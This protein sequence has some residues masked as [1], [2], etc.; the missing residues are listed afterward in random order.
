[1]QMTILKLNLAVVINYI[2]ALTICVGQVILPLHPNRRVVKRLTREERNVLSRG[3]KPLEVFYNS[4]V[5]ASIDHSITPSK[6]KRLSKFKEARLSYLRSSVGNKDHPGHRRRTANVS[7]P[8]PLL[9]GYGSHYVTAYVGTPPQRT[10]LLVDT[11]SSVT[12]FP[13]VCCEDGCG[14]HTDSYFD[15][16]KSETYNKLS[17]EECS[18]GAICSDNQCLVG[19]SYLEGSHWNGYQVTDKFYL[20]C[21]NH[22]DNSKA[23]SLNIDYTFACECNESG[24]FQTQMENGIMGLIPHNHHISN[25]LFNEKKISQRQFSICFGWELK[26]SVEGVHSGLMVIGGTDTRHHITPMVYAK[27]FPGHVGYSVNMRS[28]YL[29]ENNGKINKIKSQESTMGNDNS[30]P[31]IVDTGTTF[32]L[33]SSTFYDDFRKTWR[34]ITGFNFD[35]DTVALSKDQL[36]NL[37]V[38]LMQLEG[39]AGQECDDDHPMLAKR[40]DSSH[41]ND[42]LIEI[43]PSHYLFSIGDNLFSIEIEFER[44]FTN[45]IIGANV[46]QKHDVLFDDDNSQIGFARSKCEYDFLKESKSSSSY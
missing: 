35:D 7:T 15:P 27:T 46:L 3:R 33:L 29:A 6:S 18:D 10:T 2:A 39:T 20:G 41:C 13:C 24:L 11:G 45:G 42:V 40:V 38:L 9:Q 4:A 26:S 36:R 14:A 8:F 37:P 17:C 21:T 19:V 12:A 1:M 16:A 25:I 44:S 34:D 5:Y 28:R 43:P 23:E 32:F 30:P 31:S 22:E